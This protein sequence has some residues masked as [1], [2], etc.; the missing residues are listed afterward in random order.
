VETPIRNGRFVVET[1]SVRR[2]GFA[3]GGGF[4]ALYIGCAFVMLTVPRDAA[5]RFFNSLMHGIDV[6]PIVRWDMPWG[7][8]VVGVLEVYILGWLFGAT[9][10]S[11]YNLGA[12]R[13]E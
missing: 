5:V 3:F 12:G 1:L 11:L 7:E 10:A 6:A 13:K 9:L 4:A 2:F 8:M